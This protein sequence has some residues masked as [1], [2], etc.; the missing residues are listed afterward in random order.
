MTK[1]PIRI[2]AIV[3]LAGSG[4]TTATEY[5][6]SKG[7]PKIKLSGHQSPDEIQKQ[8]SNLSDAG[9]H[10]VVI[11][12][13]ASWDEYR[14][15]K[16]HF[17]GELHL[18]SL[19]SPRHIRKQHLSTRADNPMSADEVDQRDW[20]E[21]EQNHKSGPIAVADYFVTNEHSIERLHEQLDITLRLAGFYD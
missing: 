18:L 4:K 12:D 17:P 11:D 9:Q 2:V 5:L 10:S 15:L 7:I 14:S 13:I 1:H 3:G 19:L 16:H 20:N 21:I 8:I 6:T